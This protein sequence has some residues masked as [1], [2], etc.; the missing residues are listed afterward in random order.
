[1]NIYYDALKDIN[2]I[3]FILK[4]VKLNMMYNNQYNIMMI[5]KMFGSTDE[6]LII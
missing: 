5:K 3:Y 1:M 2:I 6:F 4:C